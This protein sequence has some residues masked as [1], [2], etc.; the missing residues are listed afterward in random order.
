MQRSLIVGSQIDALGND[1][2]DELENIRS[3]RASDNVG[4][5]DLLDEL[6]QVGL[7]V[8]GTVVGNGVAGGTLSA[9]L[10]NMVLGGRVDLVDQRV[11]DIS[12]DNIIARVVKEAGDKATA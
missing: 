3:N 2:G 6:V 7:G 5:S 11:D 1:G 9:N 8:D 4:S 12:K 10:D